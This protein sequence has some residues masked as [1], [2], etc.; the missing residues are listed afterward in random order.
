MEFSK[1]LSDNMD[2]LK[3]TL[4]TAENFDVVY[5]VVKIGGRNACLYF[6]DGL[7]KDEVLLKVLQ[8]FSAIKP[9]DMP[10]DAHGFS[11][12]YIPYGEIGLLKDSGTMIV[13][14]LTG[15]SCLFIDGYDACLTLDCRTYPARSVSEPDKD[16]VLRGS[17]DG[18]VETLIFNTALIR[19]RIRDPKLTMEI[20]TAGES[21]HTDIAICYMKDRVDTNLLDKIKS[22]IQR[23]HVD[24]L[25]MNQESLAECIYPHKWYNPFPKFRFSERPDTAAASILEGNII[26]LVDNSPSAMILPSS[27]FDIIEE[28]DDYY[29]P[30]ITGTYLRL[31]RM[32]IFLL[33]LFLTP[34]WL[35]FMQNPGWIPEW[36]AFIQ[37]TDDVHVALIFQLLILEF[38]IDGLRLAAVNTPSMLT[39]PLS[40]IAGIVLGEYSVKSGWFNSETMLYMAF[41]TIANYSQTSFELGYALKFMRVMLLLLTAFFNLWGFIAGTVISV[42]CLIF[43]KTIAGKS[44]IYP[45]VP[46]SFSE[47][48]KRLVR[49]RLPHEEKRES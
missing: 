19:R 29:F 33:T 44:Y 22:R 41:V 18:F 8:V 49:N 26:I 13:Q 48:K 45:L 31:S 17:R 21:S 16:K 14:L 20:M 9:E 2:Y 25:T 35:L 47:L 34:L 15:I 38:A 4:H 43:N 24:A 30:P 11:K 6:V 12:Q 3:E 36:L 23:L 39:T 37:V 5:R 40:V 10:E 1:T 32:L 42:L 46:F 27:I 28:A 7:T